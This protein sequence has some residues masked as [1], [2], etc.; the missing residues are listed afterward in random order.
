[1]PRYSIAELVDRAQSGRIGYRGLRRLQSAGIDPS[2]L[3]SSGVDPGNVPDVGEALSTRR[4]GN[5]LSAI[6]RAKAARAAGE[7]LMDPKYARTVA[8]LTQGYEAP[9]GVRLT[10][11]TV[12]ADGATPWDNSL[13]AMIEGYRQRR[14][15][16]GLGGL[17]L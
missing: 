2:G 5:F 1:M 14:A 3:A 16:S 4:E 7:D 15:R 11:P 6:L 10:V 9:G 8:R 13:S 17:K 12:G